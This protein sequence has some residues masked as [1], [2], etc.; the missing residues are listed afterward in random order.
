MKNIARIVV[1]AAA[2]VSIA[3]TASAPAV[4]APRDTVQMRNI[5]CC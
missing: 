5:W 3:G 4:A 2:L 1:A